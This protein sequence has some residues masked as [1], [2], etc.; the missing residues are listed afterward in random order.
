MAEYGAF[1]ELE[2]GIS[3]LL[4]ASEMVAPDG[5]EVNPAVQYAQGTQVTV[6][7]PAG[8]GGRLTGVP[9][10]LVLAPV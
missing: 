4:H 6:R 9:A 3:G 8:Q 1:I 2:D 5:T 7:G 10:R